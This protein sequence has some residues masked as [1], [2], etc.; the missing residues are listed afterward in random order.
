M[1]I[2]H[3]SFGAQPMDLAHL[4]VDAGDFIVQ[5]ENN[6]NVAPVPVEFTSSREVIEL[7][8]R[9]WM[10]TMFIDHA[11][12]FCSSIR[13]VL[14]FALGNVPDERYVLIRLRPSPIQLS[15]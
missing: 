5:P 7:H 9:C 8:D 10:A 1:A 12:G 6:T 2:D 3:Q 14:P 11:A 4:K 15:R 13:G